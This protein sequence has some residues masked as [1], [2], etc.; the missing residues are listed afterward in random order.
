MEPLFWCTGVLWVKTLSSSWTDDGGAFGVV[1]FLEASSLETQLCYGIPSDDGSWKA[2]FGGGAAR[3]C[4][5]WRASW[6]LQSSR[7]RVR[8]SDGSQRL[9]HFV[10]VAAG[11][12]LWW[13]ALLDNC[14]CCAGQCQATTLAASTSCD[15]LA[16]RGLRRVAQL[17]WTTPV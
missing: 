14:Q 1:P 15:D 7:S 6:G 12:G 11:S 8:T 13:L 3:S 10:G 4:A 16:C 9:S 5:G 17:C 2:P